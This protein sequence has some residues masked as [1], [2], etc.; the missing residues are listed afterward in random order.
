MKK[1]KNIYQEKEKIMEKEEKVKEGKYSEKMPKE[2]KNRK[3]RRS[4]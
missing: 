2:I 4:Q 3:Q 1:I